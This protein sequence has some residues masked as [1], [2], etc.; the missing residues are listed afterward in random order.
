MGTRRRHAR[1]CALTIRGKAAI[2]GLGD[3]PSRRAYPARRTALGVLAE[4]TATALADAGL[5]KEAID[6]LIVEG[7]WPDTVSDYFGIK[8]NF[9]CSPNLQ[10]AS[11]STG[12]AMAAAASN[13]GNCTTALIPTGGVRGGGEGGGD[14]GGAPSPRI[15]PYGPVAAA[16]GWYALIAQRHTYE[17]ETT[18]E[19]RFR[20][21]V[22]RCNAQANPLAASYGQPSTIKDVRKSR[23]IAGPLHLLEC[24]M[25]C[26]G[27]TAMIMTTPERARNLRQKPVYLLGVGL[28][29]DHAEIAWAD[30]ATR[31]P[32]WVSARRAFEMAGLGPKDL[33]L[34]QLYDCYT[35]TVMCELE[36]AGFVPKGEVGPW[37][38]EHDTTY[39][40]D[41]PSNT[42]GGQ[43][44]VG[45]H[46]GAACAQIIE[47]ARPVMVRARE[48]QVADAV[49]CFVNG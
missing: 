20:V 10:G 34:A 2:V 42:N 37:F 30:R 49:T 46:G 13:A 26:P 1:R 41:F 5:T 14:F 38:E 4:A 7:Q 24:D 47:A 21:A 39:K 27:A 18:D 9:A 17:Y 8:P 36:H 25:P 40:G 35:I 33:N 48:R 23:L 43:L 31:S 15:A 19:Q 28:D 45:Q 22:S 12:T 32:A 11:G 16:N 29:I 6:G 44:S 3:L